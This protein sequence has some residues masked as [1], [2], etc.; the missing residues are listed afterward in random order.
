MIKSMTAFA[1]CTETTPTKNITVEL[2]S[3]NNRYLDCTVKISR[4]FSFLEDKVRRYVSEC[5]ISRGKL[6]VYIGVEVTEDTGTLVDIDSAYAESYIN[7]L[8]ALRDKF[9]LKDDI[10]TMTVAQNREIFTVVKKEE[11]M[12][13]AWLEIKPI[14]DQAIAEFIK[15][16]EA[17]GEKLKADILDKLAKIESLKKTIEAYSET[18]VKNYRERFENKL[19]QAIADSGVELNESLILTE[20]AIYAD[21]VAVDEEMVRLNCH[22]DSFRKIFEESTPIGRKIDFL[23]QEINREINTTGSKC[24]NADIAAVVVEVKSEL[25]KIREQIQ[26]LE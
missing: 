12:E 20:C 2:K 15:V 24:N 26:N 19:R 18:D 3:V 21:R 1:R 9:S 8:K 10:S 16:R 13:A 17:E 22:F 4:V 14:L 25:E 23:L 7:A 5:G 11:D 6:D